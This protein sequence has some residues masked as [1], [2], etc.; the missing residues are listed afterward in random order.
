MRIYYYNGFFEF[1]D[2]LEYKGKYKGV[3][4]F[5]FREF[6]EDVL[7][8]SKE[9]LEKY[10]LIIEKIRLEYGEKFDDYDFF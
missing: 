3:V 7:K 9:Y 5:L 4:E 10:V 1:I 2:C 8:V 6:I